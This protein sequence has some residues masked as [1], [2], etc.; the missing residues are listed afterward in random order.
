ME[1]NAM[2]LTEKSQ[3]QGGKPSGLLG[4]LAGRLMNIGHRPVYRWALERIPIEPNA[5]IL[6]VG[7]GGGQAL[8][9]LSTRAP[10]GDVYGIDHSIE[11][12]R[13]AARVNATRVR[14]GRVAIDH[15]AVTSLPYPDGVFD[16]VTAFETI[17]FWPMLHE[18]LNEIR[19]VLKPTGLMVIANRYPAPDSS[20]LEFLPLKSAKAYI[21]ALSAAGFAPALADVSSRPGWILV[22]APA[23]RNTE[24]VK[25]S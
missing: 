21:D 14:A 17:Q 20:W 13:L 18:A 22:T 24:D 12:V 10:Q 9:V 19:R 6:D 16:I 25:G 3:A 2:S 7:C 11:M 15:G 1:G 23:A 5:T 4:L 8:N